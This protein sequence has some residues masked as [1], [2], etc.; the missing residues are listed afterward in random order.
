MTDQEF[1]QA[2]EN[3]TLP[4]ADFSHRNHVRAAYLYLRDRSFGAA[5]DA[6]CA[7]LQRYVRHLGKADRYHET[8]TVA[9]MALVNA[10]RV[11]RD[12]PWEEFIARNPRLLDSKLLATYYSPETLGAEAARRRFLLEPR[13][14]PAHT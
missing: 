9:F 3:C 5:I 8:I 2:L 4:A 1:L 12:E 6:M 14:Q 7:T 10:H 13:S 11:E